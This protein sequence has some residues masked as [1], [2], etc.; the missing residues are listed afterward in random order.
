MPCRKAM[1][2]SLLD[3]T[4][5]IVIVK[6]RIVCKKKRMNTGKQ[7]QE[8]IQQNISR[9]KTSVSPCNLSFSLTNVKFFHVSINIRKIPEQKQ[10]QRSTA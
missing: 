9:L 2:E 6:P 4:I 5:C 3:L 8:N 10:K 7:S 1:I